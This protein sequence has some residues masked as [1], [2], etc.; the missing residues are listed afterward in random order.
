MP[1]KGL[2]VTLTESTGALDT[3]ARYL[4]PAEGRRPTRCW[5]RPMLGKPLEEQRELEL[6]IRGG[7]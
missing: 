2:G 4:M 5:P 1:T 6:G 7:Q 3:Q